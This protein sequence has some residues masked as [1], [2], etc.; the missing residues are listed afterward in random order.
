MHEERPRARERRTTELRFDV[1]QI[2]QA[3][4]HV[5]VSGCGAIEIRLAAVVLSGA[6]TLKNAFA[7]GLG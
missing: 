6:L 3:V 5:D 2:A 1:L 7:R 4:R